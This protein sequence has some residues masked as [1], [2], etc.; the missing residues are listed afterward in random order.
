[1][2]SFLRRLRFKR[3]L[4]LLNRRYL[5]PQGL[6][7][8]LIEILDDE[9]LSVRR[10]CAFCGRERSTSDDNHSDDCPYWD[11]FRGTQL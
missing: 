10:D 1:M 3:R 11:Y 2:T 8:H 4:R 6:E 5:N 7:L 9:R